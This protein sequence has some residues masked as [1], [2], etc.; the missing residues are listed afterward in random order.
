MTDRTT[1]AKPLQSARAP[2][3]D[4]RG[5]AIHIA[6]L[7]LTKLADGLIDP[8]LV[9]PWLLHAAGAPG[10]AIG[11]LVPVREAGALLPQIAF[12]RQVARSRRRA[13][14][15]AAGSA[16]QGLAALGI[17]FAALTLSGWTAGA[18]VLA[19]LAG[20]AVAR[21][22]CSVS[23]KDALAR[24]VPKAARGR[25]PGLAGSLGAA[26]VLAAAALLAGGAIPLTL[27]GVA[28]LVVVAGGCWL[29]AGALFLALPEAAEDPGAA[30]A[31]TEWAALSR[32][33]VEDRQ[34]GRFIAARALL[35]V[36]ALAPPF[37]VLLSGRAETG[38]ELGALGLLVIA[39]A[40]ASILSAW[41][42]GRL[43]D[44]SSRQTLAAA[45][46]LGGAVFGTAATAAFIGGTLGT[47]AT[48]AAIFAGQLAYEGVRMARK[49][50]LTDM[51]T[52]ATRAGYTA[53]SN[54]AIGLVLVL[55]G[56]F[57]LLAD[58]AGPQTVLAVF[59]LLALFGAGAALRLDEVQA[60]RQSSNSVAEQSGT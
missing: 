34:L 23:H 39:S 59:A 8:K 40:L 38:G 1:T 3:A 4:R 43:A 22:A 46:V 56:A 10:A 31:R 45:G 28:G 12:A 13:P 47:P 20:L 16:L 2:Q 19:A 60:R 54:T 53:L 32:A 33:L 49:V 57:G 42:W 37:L 55:G 21:A 14:V 9:L 35:A 44:R 17:G 58:V 25:V 15:W 50:H 27:S 26:L 29:A 48:A 51:T 52:D 24:T 18:A 41:L 5:P 6:A 11:A 30:P 36:T 7:T